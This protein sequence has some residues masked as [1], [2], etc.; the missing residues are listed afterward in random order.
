MSSRTQGTTGHWASSQV[1]K[2]LREQPPGTYSQAP[3][4][5]EGNHG[6]SARHFTGISHLT[7]LIAFYKMTGYTD[8]ESAVAVAHLDFSQAFDTIS[9][10]IPI[11]DLRMWS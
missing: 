5:Q 6:H 4:G 10:D 1:R 2:S 8:E 3:E 9:H 7:N 11:W